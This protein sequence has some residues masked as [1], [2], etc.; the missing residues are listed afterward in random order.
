MTATKLWNIDYGQVALTKHC[1]MQ[2]CLKASR[3]FLPFL[4]KA[5]LRV[6]S[7]LTERGS[8]L[9]KRTIERTKRTMDLAPKTKESTTLYNQ[10]NL[11][12]NERY[13]PTERYRVPLLIW[14]PLLNSVIYQIFFWRQ[15]SEINQF[16]K[17]EQI[18]VCYSP[19]WRRKYGNI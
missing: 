7:Y 4:V 17:E 5:T 2:H 19:F 18:M 15:K 16:L 6:G 10:W 12:F 11:V 14:I 13:D 9:G 1:L 8:G 3:E